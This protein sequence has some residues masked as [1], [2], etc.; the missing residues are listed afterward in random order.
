MIHGIRNAFTE[1]LLEET[2]MDDKTRVAAREK[3][4]LNDY[5]RRQTTSGE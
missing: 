5:L 3:V 2:W 4:L 1:I